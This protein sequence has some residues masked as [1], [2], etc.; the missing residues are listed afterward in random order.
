MTTMTPPQALIPALSTLLREASGVDADGDRVD[1]SF[2]SLGLDSLFLTQFSVLV[3]KRYGVSLSFRQLVSE[4]GSL[5]SLAAFLA[6]RAGVPAAADAL[7]PSKPL[8]GGAPPAASREPVLGD[9]AGASDAGAGPDAL[10]ALCMRQI[11][12]MQGQLRALAQ[13]DPLEIADAPSAPRAPAAV[14]RLPVLERMRPDAARPDAA[15]GPVR[16]D[17]HAAPTMHAPASRDPATRDPATPDPADLVRADLPPTR[18]LALVLDADCPP[19][20]GARLGRD[21]A[22]RPAWFVPSRER[23]GKYVKLD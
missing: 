2:L 18:S 7:P 11:E 1:A 3:S 16:D 6:E 13:S 19:V 10:I 15:A 4:L 23:P 22:G 20:Q 14:R 12:L 17:D 8:V 21:A 5:S 9:E